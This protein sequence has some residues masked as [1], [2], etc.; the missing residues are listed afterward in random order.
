[1]DPILIEQVLSNLL[2]NAVTHGVST[3]HIQ[4]S[5]RAD[6][7]FAVFSVVDNGIGISQKDLPTLFD[8]TFKR[9][10]TPAGDGKRNMGLGLSVCLAIIRSHGGTM[11]AKNLTV[12][13]EFS[14]RLPLSKKEEIQ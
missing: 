6:G 12:G 4:L 7:E 1:M 3:T 13:A 11:E 8:G 2:E 5:V 14:F 10:E 9:N